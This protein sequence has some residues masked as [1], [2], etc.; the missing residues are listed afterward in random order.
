[1]LGGYPLLVLEPVQPVPS[2]AGLYVPARQDARTESGQ[3]SKA[4]AWLICAQKLSAGMA[5]HQRLG[6]LT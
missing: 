5:S 4:I 1:M 3:G 2:L 6:L